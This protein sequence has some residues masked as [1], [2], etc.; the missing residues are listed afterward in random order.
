MIFPEVLAIL[1]Y[2]IVDDAVRHFSGRALETLT[3]AGSSSSGPVLLAMSL[4]AA[5]SLAAAAVTLERRDV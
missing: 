3:T 1:P 4:W 2:D 5:A